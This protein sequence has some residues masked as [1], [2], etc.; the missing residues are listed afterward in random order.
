MSRICV[1]LNVFCA[2]V[3]ANTAGREGTAALSI[4]R[5]VQTRESARGPVTLVISWGMAER[6]AL[7]LHRD[8]DFTLEEATEFA[9]LVSSYALE[10]PSLTLGDVGVL[11]IHCAE[12]RHVLET[13]WSG[14]ADILATSDLRGFVG[15]DAEVLVPGR[16][17]RLRL[18][19][20]RPSVRDCRLA[21]G[22]ERV[23]RIGAGTRFGC[24]VAYCMRV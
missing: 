10:G 9:S 11:P 19:D 8:L 14:G 21:A 13:A 18:A 22:R 12:D 6:L 4:W 23:R 15:A 2:A 24:G 5:A 20:R 16:A 17:Y 3:L 7:V 1:D